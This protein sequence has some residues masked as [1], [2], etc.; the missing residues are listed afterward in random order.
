MSTLMTGMFFFL[1]IRE[2][3]LNSFLAIVLR[4]G[5]CGVLV[6]VDLMARYQQTIKISYLPFYI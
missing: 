6:L 5:N 4:Y 3:K 1:C 2:N